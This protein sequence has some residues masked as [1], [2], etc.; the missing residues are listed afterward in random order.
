VTTPV[1]SERRLPALQAWDLPNLQALMSNR[2]L[3]WLCRDRVVCFALLHKQSI[4]WQVLLS[5][6]RFM[7]WLSVP[8]ARALF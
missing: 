4:S 5:H 3:L 7:L 1:V 8:G 6:V 2:R